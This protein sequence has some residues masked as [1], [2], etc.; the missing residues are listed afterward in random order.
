M[1]KNN[2]RNNGDGKPEDREAPASVNED[3]LGAESPSYQRAEQI[4]DELK[5]IGDETKSLNR[6][7]L[8]ELEACRQF[9]AILPELLETLRRVDSLVETALVPM[10]EQNRTLRLK[11]ID[12]KFFCPLMLGLA[13]IVDRQTAELSRPESDVFSLAF[14]ENC[15]AM[16]RQELLDLMSMFDVEGFTSPSRGALDPRWHRIKSKRPTSDLS[17]IGRIARTLRPGYRRRGDGLLIRP[18]L[19]EVWAL[20]AA[21]LG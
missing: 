12:E 16:D 21:K 3:I 13:Q 10:A 2:G 9:M 20:P 6:K 18:A 14:I 1:S 19:I 17:R 11:E 7:V 4:L 5:A 8:T 15:R